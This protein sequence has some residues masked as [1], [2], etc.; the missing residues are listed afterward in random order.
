M[1]QSSNPAIVGDNKQRLNTAIGEAEA[2]EE[3]K[4]IDGV[5]GGLVIGEQRRSIERRLVTRV[6][7]R[8]CSIAGILC[9]LNLLDS[10]MFSLLSRK[11]AWKDVRAQK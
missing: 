4:G 8:L 2:G 11:T 10:G 1:M 6:D 5:D 9:S 3:W 7:W